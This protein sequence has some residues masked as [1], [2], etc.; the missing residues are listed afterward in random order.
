MKRKI[1]LLFLG[2]VLIGASYP[3]VS[4]AQVIR[5]FMMDEP[6]FTVFYKDV[7]KYAI[8]DSSYLNLVYRFRCKA[9]ASDNK[10]SNE[11]E[12]NL[13]IGKKY[14][15]YYSENLY[16]LD[17]KCTELSKK[18][19]INQG[20]EPNWQGY[21]ILR[22]ITHNIF[23]VNNRI[24]YMD[25]VCQYEES[26]PVM[27]W[28]LAVG[29]DTVMGYKCKKAVTDFG[30]HSFNVWYTPDIPLSYGPWKFGGLPGLILKVVDTNNNYI[31]EC[32]GLTQRPELIAKYDWKYKKMTKKEWQLFEKN[33]Y[34]HAGKFVQ[35]TG[36]HVLITDNSENGFHHLADTWAAYYNPI[37]K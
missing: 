30:G 32:I 12:M 35:S 1:Q 8:L 10:C 7:S 5:S 2:I 24:P 17:K 36:V 23:V 26:I 22:D 21:E 18:Q 15:A 4:K 9:S 13:L 31:F 28:K 6:N 34:E 14:T 20:S 37:E 16:E 33:M 27:K 25:D 11:D 3:F 19:L 29:S